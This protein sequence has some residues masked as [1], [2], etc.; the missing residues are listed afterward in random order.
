MSSLGLAKHNDE[1]G[2]G[3]EAEGDPDPNEG[4]ED[5]RDD[6]PG[7]GLRGVYVDPALGELG[8][9]GEEGGVVSGA[10]ARAVPGPHTQTVFLTRLQSIKTPVSGYRGQV[11]ENV[12]LASRPPNSHEE[13]DGLSVPGL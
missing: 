3:D 13:G 10:E 11:P 5:G 2:D 7:A 1:D 6:K 8:L 9:V 12:L 4:P